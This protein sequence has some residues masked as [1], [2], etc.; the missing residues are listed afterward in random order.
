MAEHDAKSRNG[1]T[2]TDTGEPPQPSLL[3]AHTDALISIDGEGLIYHLNAKAEQLT[4]WSTAKSL[5]L[6][7]AAV[8]DLLDEQSGLPV[9]NYISQCLSNGL[10]TAAIG[11]TNLRS[12][13]GKTFPVQVSV[14]PH[15]D[16]V[17]LIS[18]ASIVFRDI[19]QEHRLARE[20]EHHATYDTLT[21]LVNRRVFE[22]R[23]QNAIKGN[24]EHDGHYV[25]GFL[26]L[27]KFKLVNDT[28]GHAAGDL[29]LKQIADRL[30]EQLRDRDTLARLGGDEFAL[31]LD[32][33]PLDQAS[34]IARKLICSICDFQFSHE[35]HTF[36]VGGCIGLVQ[37]NARKVD[38]STQLM[39]LADKACYKAKKRG[40]NQVS[41]YRYGSNEQIQGCLEIDRIK[42]LRKALKRN[43]F[44]LGLQSIISIEDVR[45]KPVQYELLL[46]LR[47]PSGD[48]LSPATFLPAAERC[49]LM[50]SIDRWVIQAAFRG[51]AR[52]R[53]RR[54]K[55]NRR[56]AINIAKHSISDEHLPDFICQQLEANSL[57]PDLICFEIS[58]AAAI[59]NLYQTSLFMERLRKKGFHFT[60]DGIGEGLLPFNSLKKLPVDYLKIHGELVSNM[61]TDLVSFAMIESI[62][63]MGRRL[64]IKTIAGHVEDSQTYR[65]LEQ[66]GVDYVQ[67]FRIAEPTIKATQCTD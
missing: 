49:G 52:K 53:R 28:A 38:S 42:Q 10:V 35:G 37:I 33:C 1:L 24:Q 61:T 22:Q 47:D 40:Q 31:L 2:I 63:N 18:G 29:L 45:A 64:D 7:L 66:M 27:D 11:H 67:G 23:L 55:K 39:Q 26:D 60:L 58:E 13:T 43:H 36:Q 44:Q 8:L 56:Y 9:E 32:N 46:R 65:L 16:P 3:R 34:E 20:I 4:G 59:H 62:I 48:I 12:R 41:I 19:S 21:G 17:G 30:L 57:S 25:L 6:P 15:M 14:V 54:E 50:T 51:I 5:G